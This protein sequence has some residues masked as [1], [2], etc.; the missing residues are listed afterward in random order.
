MQMKRLIYILAALLLTTACE[1]EGEDITLTQ[2]QRIESFL[3]SSHTPRLISYDNLG[4]YMDDSAPPQFYMTFGRTAFRYIVNYYDKDRESRA[5]VMHGSTISIT[6]S[7]YDF[8][9]Y[10]MPNKHT[11]NIYYSNDP[12]LREAISNNGITLEGNPYYTFTPQRITVGNGDVI[13]GV[14]AALAG[15][16]VGDEVEIFCTSSE[17]YDKKPVGTLPANTPVYWH[18]VINGTE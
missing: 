12:E 18:I 16:R 11:D 3:T 13:S 6:Y 1:K 5:E 10:R 4:D 7:A 9:S 14:D 17:A 15:C 2:I 8:T